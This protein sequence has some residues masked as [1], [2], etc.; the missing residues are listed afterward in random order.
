MPPE[1]HHCLLCRPAV[2]DHLYNNR[3]KSS[4]LLHMP[5]CANLLYCATSYDQLFFEEAKK[6]LTAILQP[7]AR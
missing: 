3:N 2:Q 7:A 6:R 4:P 5:H 1:S